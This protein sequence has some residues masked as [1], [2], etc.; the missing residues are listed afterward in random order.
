MRF[1]AKITVVSVI[2]TSIAFAGT[3]PAKTTRSTNTQ[4][5]L[6]HNLYLA[7]LDG[8][9]SAEYVQFSSNKIFV[10]KSDLAKTG[11]THLYLDH[12]I[13]RLLVGDFGG[14]GHDQL[15][16]LFDDASLTCFILSKNSGE[17]R[18]WFAQNDLVSR[19]ADAIL[20]DFNAD[21]RDELLVYSPVSGGIKM[22]AFTGERGFEPMARFELGNLESAARPNMRFR[23]GD[24][25][26]DGRQD[27]AVINDQ[28]QVSVFHSVFDGKTNT[29]W[30]H[31]TTRSGF[32]EFV[33]ELSVARV[34]GDRTDDLVVH[35]PNSGIVTFHRAELVKGEPPS[36]VVQIPAIK[37]LYGTTLAWTRVTPRPALPSGKAL[38]HDQLFVFDHSSEQITIARP[39]T[40][41][42]TRSYV[43]YLRHLAPRNHY[44]WAPLDQKP[45]LV[46]KC[47]LADR[48]KE[49]RD[50]QFFRDIFTAQGELDVTEY[51]S[52]IS[53]GSLD[54]TGTHLD[55]HWHRM[56]ETVADAAKLDRHGKTQACV[57]AAGADESKYFNT[58]VLIN[59]DIDAGFHGRVILG[60]S[61]WNLSFLAHEMGHG[62]GFNHSFD[63]TDRKNSDWS[64]PGEYYDH[65]DIMS[66][67]AIHGFAGPHKVTS[68]P[69]MNAPYRMQAGWIPS[70]RIHEIDRSQGPRSVNVKLAAID[71]PEA[72]GPLVV[73]IGSDRNDFY[74]IEFRLKEG[75]DR[76]IPKDAVLVH[77][78]VKSRAILV[79]KATGGAERLPGS[80]ARYE[81]GVTL[82]VN[83]FDSKAGLAHIT[84]L[85][86]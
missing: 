9:G 52:A 46:L 57:N 74:T 8:D 2:Y 84:L 81:N 86:E 11:L 22:H 1:L 44:G 5:L 38:Q 56:R 79:N 10:S 70:Q 53:Y 34:D 73:T 28:G 7:D 47:K 50:A 65:W 82:K 63:D 31:F 4:M 14:L 67:M 61:A 66:A 20:A 45:W 15:C 35:N 23:A 27:L 42:Q 58:V 71:R 60:P 26:A 16:A 12:P 62:L 32:L 6:P 75:W 18:E 43:E 41:G 33:D 36:I 76:G 77:H 85:L 72:N 24:F 83:A 29:F 13:D 78:V 21:G 25:N 37:R 19:T 59:D 54:V 55:E 30:W 48:D 80:T 17:L 3:I 69:T 40:D 68:G 51:M 64:Q 49:H 39:S